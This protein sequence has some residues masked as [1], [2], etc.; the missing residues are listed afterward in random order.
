VTLA[1][2]QQFAFSIPIFQGGVGALVR[3]D[4]P[5]ALVQALEGDRNAAGS[6]RD[7]SFAVVGG[8]P[9]EKVLEDQLAALQLPARVARVPAY[10]QGVQAVLE[11]SASAFFADQSVLRD[12]VRRNP[13]FS[14]LR[15]MDR[16]FT[17]A[18]VAIALRRGNENARL[19]VDR[20]LSRLYRS[21]E[22]RGLYAKWF[23]EPDPDTAAYFRL[24]A[25][26]EK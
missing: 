10:A 24:S 23:G 20:A 3:T 25:L 4:A 11:R 15:V 18:P 26:P 16:R 2:A 6:L 14:D 17:T 7:Q 13:S 19:A 9:T 12:A 1:S 8:S 22:F 21:E 5:P